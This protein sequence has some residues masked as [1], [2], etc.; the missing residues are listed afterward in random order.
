MSCAVGTWRKRW[1]MSE[2]FY[3]QIIFFPNW[4][5]WGWHILPIRN[6]MVTTWFILWVNKSCSET[7]DLVECYSHV[8]WNFRRCQEPPA[9]MRRVSLSP[10]A[11]LG[12][13]YRGRHQH[14]SVR[15]KSRCFLTSQVFISNI[16]TESW[17]WVCKGLCLLLGVWI[18]S[19]VCFVVC[20]IIWWGFCVPK[21]WLDLLWLWLFLPIKCLKKMI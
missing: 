13:H 6:W 9:G 1:F 7:L 8:L 20:C 21:P 2:K 4:L 18:D 11:Y 12:C 19:G 16:R 10:V 5:W 15:A 14:Y 3:L 17:Q